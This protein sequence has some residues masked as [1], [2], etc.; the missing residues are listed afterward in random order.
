M[1]AGTDG[2]WIDATGTAFRRAD[3][4]CRIVSLVPSLTDLLCALELAPRL[5][6]RTGFCIHPREIVRRIPK[7]GGTKSLD[8]DK[9]RALAPTHLIVNIDENEKPSIDALRPFVP[10]IVVTHPIELDDNFGLYRLLGGIFDRELQAARLTDAL[11]DELGNPPP[12]AR[13][14][15]AL[16]LIWKDPWMT[17]GSQTY[18]SRML[19][20]AGIETVAPLTDIRYPVLDL[21]DFGRDACDLVL[22]SSEPYRFTERHRRALAGD[23]RLAGVPVALIDGEMVSWYGARAIEGLRYLRDLRGRLDAAPD[24]APGSA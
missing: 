19:R 17:I 16:Y 10:N 8:A 20:W 13:V 1:T 6:G 5:V 7:V 9:V 23:P 14:I 11:R 18:I 12:C 3:P 2:S 21:A 24:G 15:R 22:L 4:Q